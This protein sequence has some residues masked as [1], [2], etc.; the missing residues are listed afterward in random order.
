MGAGPR[1]WH[2]WPRTV[3][4]AAR[5]AFFSGLASTLSPR[6]PHAG[7]TPRE[8]QGIGGGGGRSRRGSV[9]LDAEA[10]DRAVGELSPR[11][12][13]TRSQLEYVGEKYMGDELAAAGSENRPMLITEAGKLAHVP[14]GSYGRNNP[15]ACGLPPAALAFGLERELDACGV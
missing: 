10:M 12:L 3:W 2:A 7:A 6:P 8:V 11:G 4:V 1:V 5:R 15:G 9:N 14:A 13:V